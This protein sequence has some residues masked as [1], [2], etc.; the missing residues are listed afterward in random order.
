MLLYEDTAL[1]DGETGEIVDEETVDWDTQD[2]PGAVPCEGLRH[3]ETVTETTVFAPEY[4]CLDYLA[5]GLTPEEWFAR[6]A[7]MIDTDTGD[8]VDLDDEAREA[9]RQ[10]AESQRAEADKRERRKV[11]ALNK[12]GDAAMLVRREFLTKLL[13]R[14]TP[15]KGAAIFTA[16]VLARDSHLLSDHNALDTTAALL[17][18]DSREAVAKLVSELPPTGDGRAQVI[19]LALVLGALENRTP[20]DA[21][22]T[23]TPSW[24][25]HVGSDHYLGWLADNDYPLAAIEEVITKAKT[26]D[27]VYEKY[28]ADAGKE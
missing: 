25:H 24:N 11:L 6:R 21:W 7:G 8:A 4:Y 20:K 17:G 26:A 13:V 5:A 19:T 14:K 3:A 1:C 2:R 15:P 23:S 18:L 28:L 9:A 10:Q 22:R 16:R 27:E 12:L